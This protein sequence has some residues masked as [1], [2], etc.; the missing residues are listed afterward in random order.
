MKIG[1]LGGG[2]TG[3]TLGYL[4]D[5][6]G[7]EF[8]ILEKNQRLG[9]LMRSAQENGF[10]FDIGGSHIIFSR[11]KKILN[12]MVKLLSKNIIRQKRNTKI[13]LKGRY[14]K[15]PF[16]NGLSDLPT[17]DNIKCLTDFLAVQTKDKAPI[18]T[19]RDWIYT[20]FGK[21]M[22]ELYMIPY[23]EKIWNFK[24]ERMS[25]DWIKIKG[26]L[27]KPNIE[28]VIKSSMGIQTEGYKE[29]L[30]F[31][32]PRKGGIESLIKALEKK[33]K[34]NIITNFG[35]KR[36]KKGKK[37]YVS[38]GIK[39]RTY[40]KVISTIPVFDLVS[41]LE[42]KPKTVI[43]SVSQLRYNSIITVCLGFESKKISDIHWMYLPEKDILTHRIAFMSNYSPNNAPK[44][45]SSVFAEITYNEGD[46]VSKL[47]NKKIINHITSKLRK[48]G[49]LSNEKLCY[50]KVYRH[51]YAYVV[52]DLNYNKNTKTIFNFLQKLGIQTCGRFAEFKYLNM[53]ACIRSAMNI[54]DEIFHN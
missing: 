28:D 47:S 7:I 17:E 54:V 21:S 19:F 53:D 27:P 12:F 18:K 30:Y 52:Y 4:L 5:K 3:L 36:V 38:D 34:K 44:G 46:D 8:E 33:I 20:T 51:K 22:A 29:Q 42:K 14:I 35:V 10:T 23:N 11:D 49:I 40:D 45:C 26:R 37:W 25:I 13:F 1:I 50:S 9:G 39:T 24:T 32:Y 41:A 16:E 2:L 48:K 31:Y 6:R 15:Y 43:R